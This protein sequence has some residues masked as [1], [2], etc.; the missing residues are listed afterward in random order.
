MDQIVLNLSADGPAQLDPAGI[1]EPKPVYHYVDD[2]PSDAPVCEGV[3]LC[4]LSAHNSPID[5]HLELVD[6]APGHS[7]PDGWHW[8][9]RAEVLAL[10][11]VPAMV[12]A[13]VEVPA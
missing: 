10:M 9:T 6:V 13:A 7:L 5:G 11:T 3:Q 8:L 4:R 1:Y 12:E 2:D